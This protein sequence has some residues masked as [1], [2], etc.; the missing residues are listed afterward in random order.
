MHFPQNDSD[1]N[2]EFEEIQRKKLIDK[3]YLIVQTS[4][5]P[6]FIKI[7]WKKKHSRVQEP[8]K[9]M[10]NFFLI[11]QSVIDSQAIFKNHTEKL[12]GRKQFFHTMELSDLDLKSVKW[13][14][15]IFC[16]TE[17]NISEDN[18]GRWC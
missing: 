17:S 11:L 18:E 1:L 3:L 10:W 8:I 13:N 2:Q 6:N 4:A 12:T 9:P 16:I 14:Y 15:W 5:L 7:Q